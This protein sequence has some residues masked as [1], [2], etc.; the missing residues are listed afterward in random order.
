MATYT[1]STIVRNI[2]GS[3]MYFDFLGI[4]GATLDDGADV[5]IPGDLFSMWYRNPQK[6]A[7]L[8]Y[9]LENDLLVVLV[10]P[11]VIRHDATLGQAIGIG[12]DNGSV[13]DTGPDYGSY[14]G[15]A[16]DL[17]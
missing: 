15:D 3:Q 8:D 2:S 13:I 17:S 5:A 7:S 10:T 11:A 4:H 12:V 16:P 9:A 1:G 14:I 6:K